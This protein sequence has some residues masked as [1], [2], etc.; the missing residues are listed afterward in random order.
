MIR[1]YIEDLPLRNFDTDVAPNG[2][3]AAYERPIPTDLLVSLKMAHSSPPLTTRLGPLKRL[4]VAARRLETLHY[5][6]RGQGTHFALAGDEC[7]PAFKDLVLRHYDWRH[8]PK[9]VAE[10]WDF[11]RIRHLEL[12]SVPIFNFLSSVSFADFANLRTLV[13]EDYS[14]H[15]PDKRKEATRAL[16]VLIGQHI[17]TLHT[18]KITCHT[19]LFPTDALARHAPALRVLSLRDHAGFGDDSQRCPTL[20]VDDVARLARTLTQL[21]TLEL[22]LDDNEV[23]P[24]AFLTAVCAFPRLRTLTIHIQT[25]LSPLESVPS[26]SDPDRQAVVWVMGLLRRHKSGGVPWQSITVNVGGWKKVML[27]RLGEGWRRLNEEGVFAERC[28]VLE[29]AED[30]EV[31]MREEMCLESSRAESSVGMNS[32]SEREEEAEEDDDGDDDDDDDNDDTP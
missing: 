6:D 32:G 1:L 16:A 31:R 20:Q 4:L 27:R 30:G 9:D 11:G 25:A 10:H 15:L 5:E 24:A 28:F 8:S 12:T 2:P 21:H 26:G 7:L 13:V 29:R 23:D 22:D 14:A 19:D 3:G 18:L 17:R